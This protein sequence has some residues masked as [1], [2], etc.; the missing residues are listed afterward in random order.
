MTNTS[1]LQIEDFSKAVR[2]QVAQATKNSQI[3]S[4]TSGLMCHFY[5]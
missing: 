4:D 2:I 1:G 5:F 3:P